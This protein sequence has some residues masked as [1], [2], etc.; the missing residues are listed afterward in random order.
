MVASYTELLGSRYRGRLDEKADKYIGYA[1]EGARRMQRLVG[2]LLKFSRAG[3][4]H[5]EREPV[6]TREVVG[7]VLGSMRHTI[8]ETGAEFDLGELPTV[9]AVPGQL[10]HVFLNLVSNAI[11]FRHDGE[12]PRVRVGAAREPDAWRFSVR[13]NGIGIDKEYAERI[14]QMFQRLHERGRY[15]GSG[16]GLAITKKIVE[17]HGGRVWFESEPGRGSEF[18]FTIPSGQAADDDGGTE[19]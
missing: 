4:Q 5:G 1:V 15:E 14:F 7:S 12:P 13:D 17:R 16:I 6:D 10:D 19:R 3:S 9:C 2:D 18:F 8:A 11:K